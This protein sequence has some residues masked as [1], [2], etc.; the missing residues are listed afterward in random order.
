MYER[1][2]IDFRPDISD[3]LEFGHWEIDCVVGKRE[4][5]STCLMT[6]VER[7]TRYGISVLIPKRSKK[8]IVNALKKVKS[9]F[10][11]YFYQMFQ[12][13]TADNGPEFTNRFTTHREKPTLFQ[14][15]LEAHGIRHKVI[16]PFTPR[17]NG[18][19]ERSHRKDNERFYA[20]HLFYSFEDFAKQLKR[21]NRRD[22]NNFP[23]RPLGWR[24]PNEVLLNYL[25]SL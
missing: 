9:L 5:K 7:K 16:R 14:K 18:K 19:V 23:M 22:Y 17:H 4:G 20:T 11:K 13:I 24:T 12:S 6:L 3:R 21:Y 15:H 8:C 10:G 25:H 2:S 1:Q